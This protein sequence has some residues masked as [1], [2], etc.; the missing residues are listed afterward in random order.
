MAIDYTAHK[1]KLQG[2]VITAYQHLEPVGNTVMVEVGT[3]A[4]NTHPLATAEEASDTADTVEIGTDNYTGQS[5]D[6][7]LDDKPIRKGFSIPVTQQEDL[8]FD[9][10]DFYGKLIGNA[11]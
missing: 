7:P 6:V 9:Q 3:G 1:V 10:V 4:E 8:K 11:I 2:S 5:V